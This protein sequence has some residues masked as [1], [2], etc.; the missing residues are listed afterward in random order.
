LGEIVYNSYALGCLGVTVAGLHFTGL[1][2]VAWNTSNEAYF[3]PIRLSEAVTFQRVGWV[4]G[5]TLGGN[6]D[7]GFY[8]LD[9]TRLAS[10]GATAQ[11]GASAL[12]V[13]NFGP[14]TV[15]PGSFYL[16]MACDLNT[17]TFFE[18]ASGTGIATLSDVRGMAAAFP[19]PAVANIV[20]APAVYRCPFILASDLST[21]GN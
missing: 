5:A 19:L 20:A 10:L 15:G 4:N 12:Q 13:V 8:G 14:A 6:V 16:A 9:G 7:V 11:V 21:F 18:G 1:T 17:A 2:A 3:I